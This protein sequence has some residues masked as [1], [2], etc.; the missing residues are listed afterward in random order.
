[1]ENDKIIA[2]LLE[3]ERKRY[4]HA[5]EFQKTIRWIGSLFILCAT[6]I[7]CCYMYFV[8]P[9]EEDISYADNGSQIVQSSTI[10]GDNGLQN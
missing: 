10:G 5:K 6:I 9:V 4:E 7:A 8:V 2:Y 3:N 1:M